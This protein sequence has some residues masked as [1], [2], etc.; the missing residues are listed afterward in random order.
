MYL[1]EEDKVAYHYIIHVEIHLFSMT[2]IDM[3]YEDI[4]YLIYN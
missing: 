3:W 1:D 2:I 4:L